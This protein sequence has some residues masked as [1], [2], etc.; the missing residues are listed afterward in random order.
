MLGTWMDATLYYAENF[1]LF[2]SVVSDLDKD[3]ASC[4]AMLQEM[5]NDSNEVK[6]LKT[7]LI[8][9]HAKFHFSVTVYDNYTYIHYIPWIQ[10]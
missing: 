9:I 8:Y 5:F 10:S 6:V 4:I 1:E 7:D 2:Y 3:D